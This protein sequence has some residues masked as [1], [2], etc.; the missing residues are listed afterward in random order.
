MEFKISL[1]NTIMTRR[2][3]SWIILNFFLTAVTFSGEGL[4]AWK[5]FSMDPKRCRENLNLK[6]AILSGIT[7]FIRAHRLR[8]QNAHH[9]SPH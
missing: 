4:L 2:A 8:F 6:S 5:N 7:A 3:V 9:H 1:D